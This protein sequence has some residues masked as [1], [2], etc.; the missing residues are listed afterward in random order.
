MSLINVKASTWNAED[1]ILVNIVDELKAVVKLSGVILVKGHSNAADG[2]GGEFTFDS[3]KPRSEHNNGTIIAPTSDNGD[4]CWVRRFNKQE[5]SLAFFGSDDSSKTHLLSA[6]GSEGAVVS[7]IEDGFLTTYMY[8]A[9]A[10]ISS[11][12]S[13]IVNGWVKQAVL[14]TGSLVW[15]N[16]YTG[17]TYNK[18]EVVRDGEWTMVAN[19]DTSDQPAPQ[20]VGDSYYL[21][22]EGNEVSTSVTAKQVV[23]GTRLT[24]TTRGFLNGYKL[25]VVS[26]QSYSVFT[27]TD[28]LTLPVETEINSFT[29]G[30]TGWV[31][32]N[33]TPLLLTDGVD[34]D[35]CVRVSVEDPAPTVVATVYDY[36][37]PKAPTV[38][39]VG[40]MTHSTDSPNVI[41]INNQD[42]N[43]VDRSGLLAGLTVG[44]TITGGGGD[45]VIQ[46]KVNQTTYWDIHVAPASV[47]SPALGATI[48]FN[49]V[50]AAN[51][52]YDSESEHWLSNPNTLG[53]FTQ[54][55]GYNAIV[56]NQNAYP[57]DLKIQDASISEDWDVLAVSEGAS[58]NDQGGFVPHT[59]D[60]HTDTNM[61]APVDQSVVTWDAATSK[62]VA[63]KSD[64][65]G[66][67][68]VDMPYR[69]LPAPDSNPQA[70]DI[71]SNNADLSL[72]T[73]LYFNHLDIDG[74]DRGLYFESMKDDDWTNLHKA[75]DVAGVYA[76]YNLDGTPSVAGNIWTVPVTFLDTLGT[77]FVNNESLI[78]TWR[79]VPTSY[80]SAELD[81]IEQRVTDIETDH[82]ASIANPHSVT[83]T[84][85]GLSNVD[86]T[87]DA[88]KPVS[89]AQQT[90]L[91][92]KSNVTAL[93]TDITTMSKAD[94]FALSEK[95]IRDNAGSGF[96][97][98]GKHDSLGSRDAVNEGM[99]LGHPWYNTIV[100]G[101][102]NVAYHSGTSRTG[103]PIISVNGV[104]NYVN[105]VNSTGTSRSPNSITF[106]PAPDGTKTYDSA[107]GAVVTHST[108]NEAFE[109]LVT[110]GDFRNGTTDWTVT[111]VTVTFP[112]GAALIEGTTTGDGYL[113]TNFTTVAGT[114]CRAEFVARNVS[115]TASRVRV[116]GTSGS[117]VLT[118][119]DS[120]EFKKYTLEFTAGDTSANIVCDPSTSNTIGDSIEV[121]SV[122]VMPVTEK[123]ITTRQDFV[124]LESFHEKISD[125]DV[126]YPLG[127]VQYGATTWEGISLSTS[128]VAQ[129]YSA[130]GEWDTTTTGRGVTW[131]TLSA[132]DKVKFLQDPENNIY[133]DDG[134]LIQVRYRMRVI[135]GLGDEWLYTRPNDTI[136]S[137]R[138]ALQYDFNYG[139]RVYAQGA[140]TT[141]LDYQNGFRNWMLDESVSGI[142]LDAKYR[143]V[144]IYTARTTD[145][146]IAHNG[147]GFAIPI[148]LVQRLNQG[149][150]HPVYNP[151]GCNRFW[152]NTG[153]QG[154]SSW[155]L[156][157][158]KEPNSTSDCFT[159][160]ATNTAGNSFPFVPSQF[161]TISS[162]TS[163]R[164]TNDPFIYYDAIYAGQVQDLRTSSNRQTT[165]ELLNEYSRK[166]IAGTIRG[167][168]SVP[169]TKVYTQ[170]S[171]TAANTTTI[172]VSDNSDYTV[173]DNIWIETTSGVYK[174]RS[175]T[176]V[177][178]DG[179]S[180]NISIASPR[181]LN[182]HILHE[183]LRTSQ[184]ETLPWQDIIGDPA[185]IAATFPD[186]VYGQ[187]I[188]KDTGG[189]DI[190]PLNRKVSVVGSRQF[191]ADNG[192][193]WDNVAN[194]GTFD[195]VMNQSTAN[196]STHVALHQYTTSAN[197]YVL[198]NNAATEGELGDVFASSFYFPT[199][200]ASLLGGLI[201]KVL[202]GSVAAILKQGFHLD[203][204]IID[205]DNTLNLNASYSPMHDVLDIANGSSPTVKTFPYI[206]SENSQY[207]LQWVYKEII[208]D[209]LGG[210]PLQL[211]QGELSYTVLVG[212]VV[213]FIGFTTIPNKVYMRQV[214]TQSGTF[215]NSG[216]SNLMEDANGN[217]VLDTTGVTY[218]TPYYTES[219]MGDNNKF[220]V[221]DSE[222]TVTD[223]N[224]NSVIVGQKRVA[225]P[226][227]TGKA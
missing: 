34:F 134:E 161:G 213:Q 95:R 94:F 218:W 157:D 83:K 132:A 62:W 44:D 110:N 102:E 107:T 183:T 130:F 100:L 50:V 220:D 208:W 53:F 96:A 28:P 114:T 225:L 20:P 16:T 152:K 169:F 22:A 61:L 131:S 160:D 170:L 76:R 26:G 29:A 165:N 224:G 99:S 91:D 117:D 217:L 35:L 108:S 127:N 37:T 80:S 199:F 48:N 4:G 191:T 147:L 24:T 79:S 210:A 23:Y 74:V 192:V 202:V 176:T 141:S 7:I 180:L 14:G 39:S 36:S 63:I 178:G 133:N 181:L 166:S 112:N 140:S 194:M 17:G 21:Y 187:W 109:G 115:G 6:Y 19:K 33:V 136:I 42:T 190:Y 113:F 103:S 209:T 219:E 149:G 167:K 150:Y 177:A 193:S 151:E 137:S 135:E 125:K 86:N 51:V 156:A 223:D 116:T 128:V 12:G 40:A 71:S 93:A 73:I 203:S 15:K 97:E 1:T 142:E 121:A 185:R 105:G 78:F 10:V 11:D 145:T 43:A 118:I 200:G 32:F 90:A 122:S 82:V 168:E 198:A 81:V 211:F 31:Y 59:L 155:Y 9:A 60:S 85:L 163:G 179:V 227:F 56:S 153:A 159:I 52:F 148:A 120:T 111:N 186:G 158:A 222:A 144:G 75:G 205:P 65:A 123:V 204:Y 126:V 119:I 47:G 195:P 143:D 106:P 27:V 182:G 212:D 70:G 104:L 175:I 129:G 54:D 89:T 146:T 214:N 3:L 174:R 5:F 173:G 69:W 154:A 196:Y 164:P 215:T 87:S 226:Y 92:L 57:I 207:Y 8:S 84:Q 46:Y 72:V 67:S 41:K 216:M 58:A 49:A 64:A 38:P 13:D 124:F 206:T 188:P 101:N 221:V 162:A 98:W 197:P 45:W 139:T 25:K 68:L 88:N 171:S 184:Y 2:G 18:N 66:L 172:T 138:S 189:D 55:G 77:P 201:N 30:T